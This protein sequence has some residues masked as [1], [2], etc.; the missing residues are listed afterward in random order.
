MKIGKLKIYLLIQLSV[1][2]ITLILYSPIVSAQNWLELPPYNTLW[3]LWSPAL[4]PVDDVTGLPTPIVS[5]LFPDTIL[6]VM[7]GLTWDPSMPY[8][9]LLYNTFQGLAY[10]DPLIGINLWPAPALLDDEGLPAPIALPPDYANLPVT[11]AL[12]LAN[13]VNTA[14]NSYIVSYPSV[15]PVVPW[16]PA[17]P[18]PTPTPTLSDLLT[19]F[20]ILGPTV[21]VPSILTPPEPPAIPTLAFSAIIFPLSTAPVTIAVPIA[22]TVA[23]SPTAAVSGI[24]LF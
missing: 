11:D 22:P 15:I 24:F 4:S 14:N 20:D 16:I 23:A 19:P 3:P 10:F 6:P 1:F 13:Y 21:A 2:I 5:S 12:W 9:W 17:I 8:P 7:P 18:L